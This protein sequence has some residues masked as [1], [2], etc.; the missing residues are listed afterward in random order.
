MGQNAEWRGQNVEWKKMPNGT[1][2]QMEKTSTGTKGQI[3]RNIEWK[4]H[5][6]EKM[7]NGTKCRISIVK[8]YRETTY[9]HI[10]RESH[11]GN[12]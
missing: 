11:T 8:K 1:K 5:R 12:P 9:C 10:L 2:H 6:M 3:V 7:P 4:K